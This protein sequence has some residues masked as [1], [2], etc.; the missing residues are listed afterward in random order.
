MA[1]FI[2]VYGTPGMDNFGKEP[3][4]PDTIV[5]N[6]LRHR[7]NLN[8]YTIYNPD[9]PISSAIKL[10]DVDRKSFEKVWRVDDRLTYKSGNDNNTIIICSDNSYDIPKGIHEFKLVRVLDNPRRNYYIKYVPNNVTLPFQVSSTQSRV[11]KLTSKSTRTLPPTDRDNS[12]Q[13][14]REVHLESREDR[15]ERRQANQEREKDIQDKE[16]TKK[17]IHDLAAKM[18]IN[19]LSLNADM[20]TIFALITKLG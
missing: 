1:D 4:Q 18:K 15:E 10:V 14:R 2:P 5:L 19:I 3:E 17:Q 16:Q 12:P 6:V 11:I 7:G 8:E 13:R 9:K 20:D